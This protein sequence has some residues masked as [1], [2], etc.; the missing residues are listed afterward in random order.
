VPVIGIVQFGVQSIA[1][2]YTYV[3]HVGLFVLAAWGAADLMRRLP[4]HRHVFSDVAGAWVVF[5]SATTWGQAGVWRDSLTLFRHSA[6]ATGSPARL[7]QGL[8][9]AYRERGAGRIQGGNLDGA[10]ED[11]RESDRYKPYDPETLW[12]LGGALMDAGR[13]GEAEAV[14]S[15]LVDIDPDAERGHVGLGLIY[16]SQGRRT[17]PGSSSGGRSRSTLRAGRRRPGSLRPADFR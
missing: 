11:L 15:R 13:P 1:D 5:L 16:E 7:N 10:I 6:D 8:G 4:K 9:F 2:R 14:V 12:L 3:P 17:S